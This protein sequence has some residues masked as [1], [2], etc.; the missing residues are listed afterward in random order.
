MK[1]LYNDLPESWKAAIKW[2]LVGW[3]AGA[4]LPIV[5]L[6]VWAIVGAGY[7]IPAVRNKVKDV[8]NSLRK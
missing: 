5:T 4:L 8:F 2:A 6:P 7:A 1:Q 3:V